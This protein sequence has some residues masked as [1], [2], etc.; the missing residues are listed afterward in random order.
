[1]FLRICPVHGPLAKEECNVNKSGIRCKQCRRK[2]RSTPEGKKQASLHRKSHR[3]RHRQALLERGKAYYREHSGPM[4]ASAREYQLRTKIEVL[5]HYAVD[6]K[7]KCAKCDEH[8]ARFLALDHVDG[9]GKSHC[10]DIGGSGGYVYLWARKNNFPPIFQVLCHN[11]NHL[12]SVRH[13]DKPA[14]RRRLSIKLKV[15]SLYS[16]GTT[17]CSECDVTDIRLLTIDYINDDG[18]QDRRKL[19]LTGSNPFYR[20]LLR[21]Q[22]REDLQVL[23]QKHNLGKRCL[24]P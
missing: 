24:G 18:A 20:Y 2:K 3:K 5:T 17:K 19:G 9:G 15:M 7:L 23:C 4:R 12:K 21:V 11:C 6:G 16:G 14:S 8:E 10:R 13:S 22:K 1:M